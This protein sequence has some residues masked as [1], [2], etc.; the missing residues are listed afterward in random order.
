MNI[1][2]TTI[3]RNSDDVLLFKQSL[4]ESD[5]VFASSSKMSYSLLLADGYVLTP[6]FHDKTYIDFLISYCQENNI[7]AIFSFSEMDMIVLSK[8]KEQFQKHGI[9][10]VVSD[11]LIIRL[12]N[13]KW[14]S[15]QFLLSLGLKQPKTYIDINLLKQDIK[16]GIVSFP[17]F[18]KPRWGVGSIGL[19]QVD[20]FEEIDIIYWKI[21]HKIFNSGLK[22]ESEQDKDFCVLMQEKIN[23]IEH[24]IDIFNDLNGNY[25]TC[26]PKRKLLMESS[27]KM[28]QIVWDKKFEDIAKIISYNLKHI[29]DLDVDCFLT[30]T[31]EIVV[32][33][34]NCRFGGQYPFS[35]LA[36]ARFPMQIIDWLS[37]NPTSEKYISYNVGVTGYKDKQQVV[38]F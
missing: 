37:G 24:G 28:A 35:H 10:V 9:T 21:H 27:T 1:L 36:G 30:E 14:K 4:D 16:S 26:V 25:V 5:K 7:K 34:M 12:C 15:H 38:R 23:G 13:D 2:I 22:H 19:F 8:N 31:G 17:L 20:A 6:Q 18:F 32:L 11:E 3:F 33:E 29:S